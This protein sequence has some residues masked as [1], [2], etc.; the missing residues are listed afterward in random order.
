MKKNRLSLRQR[1]A[2]MVRAL[3]L[4]AGDVERMLGRG[5]AERLRQQIV[6]TESSS[7]AEIRLC[8]EAALP[9]GDLLGSAD[10]DALV[11]RRA[12]RLFAELGVWDTEANT[13]VLIY[14]LLGERAVEIV[15]D[16]GLGSIGSP[17]WQALAQS[18]AQDLRAGLKE[19]ALA[20]AME[21]CHQLLATLNLP[22]DSAGNELPDAPQVQ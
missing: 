7:S 11:R 18:L 6:Q 20:M 17:Q 13:G 8:V 1:M 14:V 5:W 12:V 9:L 4:D 10:F 19:K 16:R 21:R 15:A 2:C 22:A 3:W